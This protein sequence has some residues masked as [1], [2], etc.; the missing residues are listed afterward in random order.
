MEYLIVVTLV[1]AVVEAIKKGYER[2]FRTVAIIVGAALVG[3][4]CGFFHVQGLV[5]VFAGIAVGLA[6]SGVVTVANKV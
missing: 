4:I 6:A 1:V 5:D 2:D 3:G